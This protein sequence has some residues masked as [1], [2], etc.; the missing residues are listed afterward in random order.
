M[1]G[2]RARMVQR[3]R[4]T[5]ELTVLHVEISKESHEFLKKLAGAKQMPMG[6]VLDVMLKRKKEKLGFIQ[7]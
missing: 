5:L 6:G 2:R 3:D 4:A 1:P 7:T